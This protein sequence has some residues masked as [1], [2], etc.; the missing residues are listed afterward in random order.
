MPAKSP[1][2][3]QVRL[4]GIDLFNREPSSG[5]IISDDERYRYWLLRRWAPGG[6]VLWVML[7]PS[8]ADYQIDDQTI[9]KCITFSKAWGYGAIQVVNLYAIRSTDP[10][11]LAI[12]GD[13]IGPENDRRIG[14]A[15]ADSRVALVLCAWGTKST[16][17]DRAQDVIQLI[18]DA[19]HTPMCLHRTKAG[20]PGHPLYL[21]GTLR[22]IPLKEMEHEPEQR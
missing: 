2:V 9:R 20:H 6:I 15:L 12:D 11:I 3:S 13:A 16:L 5:A 21:R 17:A 7:N 10:S 8:T 14:E 18:E 4:D 19:G 1:D 22:P